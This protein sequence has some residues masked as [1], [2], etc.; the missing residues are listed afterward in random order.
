MEKCNIRFAHIAIE[1]AARAYHRAEKKDQPELEKELLLARST[2]QTTL[3]LRKERVENDALRLQLLRD[4][5]YY[6]G[7]PKLTAAERRTFRVWGI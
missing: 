1:A 3:T 4:A 2:L 7:K 5:W 6:Q